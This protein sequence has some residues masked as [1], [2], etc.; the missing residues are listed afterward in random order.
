MR[1]LL[2]IL[3]LV[4]PTLLLAAKAERDSLWYKGHEYRQWIYD[5]NSISNKN[6][7]LDP[8]IG[9]LEEGR[10]RYHEDQV[11]F[12]DNIDLAIQIAHETGVPLAFYLFDH[13]CRTCL[14]RLPVLYRDA[15]VVEQS[16]KFINVYVELPRQQRQA[17]QLGMMNASLTVQFFLP[18]MR[19]LRVLDDAEKDNLL[20]TYRLMLNYVENLS[21]EERLNRELELKKSKSK[22]R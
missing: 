9:F 2:L 19:R 1:R 10:I 15:E 7:N 11:Y 3:I 14:Y 8:K 6:S 17:S 16:R 21:F 20:E 22:Y 18:S 4:T 13:T 5:Q 12:Y